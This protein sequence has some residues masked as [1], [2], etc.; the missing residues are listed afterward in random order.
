MDYNI[1]LCDGRILNG[2]IRSPGE[3]IRGVII[4]VHGLGEHIR[5]YDQWG[6]YFVDAGFAFTGMDLPGHGYSDGRRGH[7]RFSDLHEMIT[8]L[9]S[10]CKKTFPG[11]PVIVYGHS[12]GGLIVLDYIL[13]KKPAVKG[14]IVTSPL[15]KLAFEPD[16]FRLL[17]A[18]IVKYI[19]PGLI[20]PTSL[21]ADHLSHDPSVVEQ[22]KNDALVH[23]KVSIG[24]FSD[25]M[26]SAAF[27]LSHS[28][29]LKLPVVLL[30]GSDDL[31]CSPEGSREFASGTS[32]CD[33]KIWDSGHHE[34]H[35]EPFRKDVFKYIM[36]WM[37]KRLKL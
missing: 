35:N 5:R 22:Y 34:L 31:I 15:L 36:D 10:E 4:L 30:H 12:L 18:K 25:M 21:I 26:N 23:D 1:R 2:V 20:Q 37:N 33:L 16:K 24:A 27:S 13:R 9:I 29:D 6:G 14:A 3:R 28:G 7:F 8:V 11:I 17:L 19:L 32:F